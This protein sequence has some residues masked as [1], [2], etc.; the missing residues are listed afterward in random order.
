MTEARLALASQ[1]LVEYLTSLASVQSALRRPDGFNYISVEDYI[2]DRGVDQAHSGPLTEDERV[3]LFRTIDR[4]GLRF[5]QKKCFHNAQLLAVEDPTLQY[6]EGFAQ[7][8]FGPVHHA[9]LLLNGKLLDLTWRTPKANHRGRLADRILGVIP[10]GWCYR[11]VSFGADEI[12]ERI[13]E[14]GETRAFIGDYTRGFPLLHRERLGAALPVNPRL[15][16]FM[17]APGPR[18]AQPLPEETA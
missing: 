18:A 10:E 6:V 9:W 13:G 4:S 3:S 17:G 5:M 8:R 1:G 7:S 15:L 2:L 16:E 12:R 11:G 14:A